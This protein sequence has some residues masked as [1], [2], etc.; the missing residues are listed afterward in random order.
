MN[1]PTKKAIFCDK[2]ENS[3]NHSISKGGSIDISLLV[4]PFD[5]AFMLQPH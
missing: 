1:F 2:T 3:S 5:I 4:Y